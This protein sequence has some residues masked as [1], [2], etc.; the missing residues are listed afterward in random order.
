ML[1][2]RICD[3]GLKVDGTQLERLV[4]RLYAE[5]DERG[6]CFR[7]AVWLS[8][9]WFSPDGVPGI[10]IPFYLAHRRLVALEAKQ[11]LEVEGGNDRSCM[12]VLRHEAGHAIDSAYRLHFRKGWRQTFGRY[13]EPY[14]DYYRPKPNSRN[15]VLHLDAWYAQAHPAEDFAE[16]FAVWLKPRSHWRSHYR[17]WPAALRKLEYVD[18]TMD[19]IAGKPPVVLRR[20]RVEP[21]SQLKQTLGEYYDKKRERYGVQWSDFYDRDLRRLFSDDR[22]YAARPT[23]SSFLR[24]S[25]KK[26]R[27]TVSEWTGAH[28]YTIDQVLQEMIERCRELKLRVAVPAHEARSGALL[29]LTKHTMHRV[30]VG[31]HEIPL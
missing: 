19:E 13:S 15:Y 28:A 4:K 11:M 8:S 18:R 12:R 16:T 10:A 27:E 7:P 24:S 1:A 21:V 17:D 29:L 31:K 20:E 14:P 23:A 30:H 2:T 22:H 6:L 9:E 26:I 25:R 5:L 3:L